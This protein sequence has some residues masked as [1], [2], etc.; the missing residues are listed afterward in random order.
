MENEAI[1]FIPK[2]IGVLCEHLNEFWEWQINIG[3]TPTYKSKHMYR[4]GNDTYYFISLDIDN[5]RALK[6]DD[7]IIVGDVKNN[8]KL[9][10]IFYVLFSHVKPERLEYVRKKFNF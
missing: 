6:L 5:Y 4:V 2:Y 7:I 3:H 10:E 8:K 9:K 1:G